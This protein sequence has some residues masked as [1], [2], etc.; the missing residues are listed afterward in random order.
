MLSK[1]NPNRDP[2]RH[3][4]H[5]GDLLSLQ[6]ISEKSKISFANSVMVGV[7]DKNLFHRNWPIFNG[8]LVRS[9]GFIF[10]MPSPQ[11]RQSGGF[12]PAVLSLI[13]SKIPSHELL[14]LLKSCSLQINSRCLSHGFSVFILLLLL[15]ISFVCSRI[16]KVQDFG[17]VTFFF[18]LHLF[19]SLPLLSKRYFSFH[20]FCIFIHLFSFR[21]RAS[22]PSVNI[23]WY[24]QYIAIL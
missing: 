10:T 20:F 21:E 22:Y 6:V 19:R 11:K 9:F 3:E 5:L 17:A 4:K 7:F 14:N 12:F 8:Q 16:Y 2:P 23:T 13:A 15:F 24:A 1:Q 18:L